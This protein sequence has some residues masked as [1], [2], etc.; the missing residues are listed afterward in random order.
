ME[1]QQSPSYILGNRYQI[2]QTL[3]TG[4]MSVVYLAKDLMLERPVALKVLRP[5]LTT[6]SDFSNKFRQ[7]AKAAAIL[8]HPNIVTVHD[9]GVDRG[10][11]YIVMEYVPG[12]D[13]KTKIKQNGKLP[14][15]ETLM[16]MTQACAG[17]GYA[18]RA[19][20]V[21]CDVKPQNMIVTPEERL[22]IT[23]FGISRALSTINPDEKSD[24]VWG[25]PQYFSPEQA[26][27]LAPSP[28]SDVYS[29]GVILYE[30][31]TGQ[32]PFISD[33]TNEL[34]RMHRDITPFPPQALEPSIPFELDRIIMKILSKEPSSRYRTAD[35]LGRILAAYSESYTTIQAP[36]KDSSKR[37]LP[38]IAERRPS[39][40]VNKISTT[41]PVKVK[42]SQPVPVDIIQEVQKIDWATLGMGLITLLVFGGLIPFWLYV[43]FTI[44]T[45]PIP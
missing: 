42:P 25:S 26:A 34:V 12:L 22:K 16:L 21:H 45:S 37:T 38:M 18:H 40:A 31:L 28:A 11:L 44:T 29:I 24:V 41:R 2:Q 32:L 10:R 3:G 13:L 5:D 14:I 23:D 20:L 30:M 19:G 1:K 15:K 8:S 17:L 33:D 35:Q 39:P 4:G 7:E 43:W 9:F 6:N 36:I 27:G